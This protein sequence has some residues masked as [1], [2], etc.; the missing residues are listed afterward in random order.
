MK[1]ETWIDPVEGNTILEFRYDVGG[2]LIWADSNNT[3][4]KGST[5]AARDFKFVYD[6]LGRITRYE[7]RTFDQGPAKVSFDNLYNANGQL[8]SHKANIGALADFS[9]AYSYNHLGDL[10]GIFQG[11]TGV[12]GKRVRFGV[13]QIGQ[14][15]SIERIK[16]A[17]PKKSSGESVPGAYRNFLYDR[18]G[19]LTDITYSGDKAP[20][21]YH[22][23]RDEQHRITD[24]KVD[25]NNRH[26]Q[27]FFDD[28]LSNTPQGPLDYDDNHNRTTGG[29]QIG[30]DNRLKED[31]KFKYEYDAEG[32]L[33]KQTA[34]IN[35]ADGHSLFTQVDDH[36]DYIYDHRNRLIRADIFHILGATHF[37]SIHYTYDAAD[38]LVSRAAGALAA[39]AGVENYAY[40]GGSDSV[41]VFAGDNVDK[42]YLKSRYLYGPGDHQVLAEDTPGSATAAKTQTRWYLPDH[43]GSVRKVVDDNGKLVRKLDYDAFGNVI[44]PQSGGW[45]PRHQYTG[46]IADV[47]TGIYYYGARWYDPKPARFLNQ[48]PIFEGTNPYAH[49]ANNPLNFTDPTGL[50]AEVTG[51]SGNAGPSFDPSGMLAFT[52]V[53]RAWQY[54]FTSHRSRTPAEIDQLPDLYVAAAAGYTDVQ[55]WRRDM[56]Y[57]NLLNVPY[58]LE[59]AI[60]WGRI[61]DHD[62]G[63]LIADAER[64]G[65][66]PQHYGLPESRWYGG[67][68]PWDVA[69]QNGVEAF[70]KY[71]VNSLAQTLTVGTWEGPARTDN[72][73]E[74]YHWLQ[75]VASVATDLV[76]AGAG[77]LLSSAR[78]ARGALAIGEAAVEMRAASRSVSELRAVGRSADV[79]AV[80]A[81]A[82]APRAN[83][84]GS[85]SSSKIGIDRFATGRVVGNGPSASLNTTFIGGSVY[86]VGTYNQL[87]NNA[88]KGTIIH[89]VPSR[90]RGFELVQSYGLTNIGTIDRM[91]GRELAIRLPAS[92][93][94]LV[95]KAALARGRIPVSARQELAWQIREL[96]RYTNAPNAQ[97]KQLIERNKFRRRYD[98]GNEVRGM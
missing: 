89:H 51:M 61:S 4:P 42:A 10:V 75:P 33:T 43:E 7:E 56:D 93:A 90:L 65:L 86:D 25:G 73:R 58:G 23:T 74:E 76:L 38:R 45:A 98:F 2:R 68:G 88:V 69:I 49:V 70:G 20:T 77:K 11:G 24:F 52:P 72:I 81:H 66:S 34:K 50:Y 46:Q 36:I 87:A 37:A 96:R 67:L 79:F 14:V 64:R 47:D 85:L 21:E 78:A 3:A 29:S 84:F 30:L 83:T 48:D 18:A 92:E 27:Y 5:D 15:T 95:D 1:K 44:S 6:A 32:N 63:G 9:N 39:L 94:A 80:E 82:M 62:L 59:Q 19:Y 31:T 41:F 54:G 22:F 55:A 12:P 91:A 53:A 8:T 60:A 26:Y 40:D 35:N 71:A 16:K 57:G 28:Q 17:G 13:N 97:L